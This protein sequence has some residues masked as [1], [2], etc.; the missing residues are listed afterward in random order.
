MEKK[1]EKKTGRIKKV[2][3]CMLAVFCFFTISVQAQ[4]AAKKEIPAKV[5][6]SVKAVLE[7]QG[8]SWYLTTGDEEEDEQILSSKIVYLRTTKGSDIATGYYAFNK[9]GILDSR[10]TFHELDTKIMD[11]R[12]KGKYYFGGENGKLWTDKRGWTQVGKKRYYF[13]Q[14]GRM[15][16]NTWVQGYYLKDDGQI[17]KNMRTP[18]GSYVDCDGRKCKKEEMSLSSLKKQLQSMINGYSGEWSVYVKDLKTGDVISI[19]DKAMK[20]ASVI[21]LFTMAATYDSIKSGKIQKTSSV[22]SL[23][24]DM[25][26]VSDNESFNELVRRNSSYRSFTDGCSV[27]NKYLKK[28]GCTK[29]GCHSSL[30]PSNSSFTWDGQTNMASAKDAGLI[31][32][33]V[34]KG[35]CVSA[36]YSKEMLN[37]LLHQTRRW[38]I[39]AGLPAGTK[40]ANKTGENDSCQ[41]DVAIVYGKKTNYV[42]CIFSQTYEGSGVSRIRALSSKIYRALNS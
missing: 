27:I 24:E 11:V 2:L 13:S 41:N 16:V 39:P 15:Y 7:K 23:L 40:C 20:P 14:T 3:V 12:F 25:I 26:T 9:K 21:K 33:K 5:N 8:D 28:V 10:R 29:T 18:D 17:A 19:N 35:E 32:E 38:K 31:L 34:Y 37:L 22:N 6:G 36:K 42:V 4:A 30:H 1:M